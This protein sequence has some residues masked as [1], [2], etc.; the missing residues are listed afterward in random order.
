MTTDS[1]PH[2]LTRAER[3]RY[4]D[5]S[6][7]AD[8][9]D[10]IGALSALGDARLH[11]GDFG[12]TPQGRTLPLLVLSAHGHFTPEAAHAS[13]LP[14][15]LAIC[16]IHAGEV[17]GKEA[18]L[19]LVRDLLAGRHGDVLERLTLVVV[20][21]F[22]ADGN[23]AISPDNR[24]LDIANLHGQLGPDSGVGTRN[25]PAGVN[26]NRDYLRQEAPE[27]RLLQTRVC[28]AW[29]A[30]L[31]V[32]CHATNGSIHRFDLTYDV[33]HT[34]ESGRRE[35]ID[36]MRAKLLPAVRAAVRA[37]DGF[38]TFWY[39]NFLRD[40]GGQGMG[41][42][43]YTHHP[44]FGGNYRGLTNRMD[45]L[46]EAYSYI[47]FERRVGV[48]YA[49][50]RETLHYVAAH[51]DEIVALLS[52]CTLPPDR[53]A[54]RY[55]LEEIAGAPA[56]IPTRDPYALDGAPVE[57]EVPHLGRFV[58]DHVVERPFA[59]A[60]PGQIAARLEGH[61]LKVERPDTAP[62]L[63]AR[64]ATVR[65]RVSTVGREILEANA[66]SYLDA[67]YRQETRALPAGWALVPTAQPYG[68][69]AVY[70]CEAGSDDSLVACGWAE[71]PGIGEE[72]PAWRVE[73]VQA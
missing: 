62:R 29:N 3:S 22:N 2:P 37:H 23:E 33:P 41:W 20:P 40:E 7:H 38:D 43:T 34:L 13:G 5:T 39:G 59:Y 72:F 1:A 14:V 24:R 26:L 70:L 51:G 60:V 54:V 17:E 4:A 55:R 67:D 44:R 48:T 46:L 25:T 11:I 9:M 47:P 35:P 50:L 42:I 53:I 71:E 45:L 64:I 10:F 18:A 12:Q 57:V 56:T 61:G 58:G 19:M 66:S 6:R 32:D 68:A 8:V 27:M 15:V 65:G 28:H 69:I 30:H 36:Y 73:A 63:E 49:F 52:A 21:L 16:G 31:I